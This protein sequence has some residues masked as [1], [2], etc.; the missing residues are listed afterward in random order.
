MSPRGILELMPMMSGMGDLGELKEASGLGE[1]E[2][3]GL[4]RV[5]EGCGACRVEGN[6]VLFFDG[7]RIF[8]ALEALKLGCSI[9]EVSRAL[10]WR[11]F[12][13]FASMILRK[14]GFECFGD[15]RLK[16]PRVQID[17]FAKRGGLGVAIDCKRWKRDPGPSTMARVARMQR[18]RAELLARS[19]RDELEGLEYVIPAI[20]TI[21]ES[22][23]RLIEGIPIIPIQK[24]Q[25]FISEFE[26]HLG[27]LC[28]I[29]V[30]R[31][32]GASSDRS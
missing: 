19:G 29:K 12:E 27:E 4:L 17:V 23:F 2:L 22:G 25:G 9:E 3:L 7:A 20:L 18:R 26:G 24:F 32:R 14:N 8:A 1:E 15:L 16:K 5:L 11:D 10:T 31:T 28:L 13:G 30:P 6:A 21:Y